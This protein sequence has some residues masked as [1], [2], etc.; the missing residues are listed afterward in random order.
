VRE[1]RLVQCTDKLYGIRVRQRPDWWPFWLFC[2]WRQIVGV[3]RVY[4]WPLEQA[5]E[6]RALAELNGTAPGVYMGERLV[7][8]E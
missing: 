2:G 6:L 7:V 1:A 4:G 3:D 5:R 8:V